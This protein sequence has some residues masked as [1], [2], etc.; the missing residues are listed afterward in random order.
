MTIGG[1]GAVVLG[2]VLGFLTH[3]LVR[4]DQKAG[5]G[6]LSVIVGVIAGGIVMDRFTEGHQISWYFIGL[7]IGFFIYWIF[8]LIGKEQ[9]KTQIKD[10]KSL[11]L[12]PFRLSKKEQ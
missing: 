11:P 8:L 7:G 9:V 1:W 4:R 5:I 2:V 3:Y 6:D 12:L 10:G